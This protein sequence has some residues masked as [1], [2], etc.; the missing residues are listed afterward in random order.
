[1]GNFENEMQQPKQT[2]TPTRSNRKQNKNL[3]KFGAVA[4]ALCLCLLVYN[5]SGCRK[6]TVE[7]IY[8]FENASNYQ[9]GEYKGKI[10]TVSYDGIKLL[11]LDGSQS[12][13]LEFHMSS[14]HL[15]VSGN[16]ILLYDKGNKNLVVYDGTKKLYSYECDQAIKTAKVNKNGYVVLISDEIAYNSRVTVLDNKGEDTYIWKIGDEYIVDTDIS[17]DNKKLVAT[18]ISTTTGEIVENV[19]FVDIKAAEETGRAKS[20][21]DMPLQVNFANSG[22]A[23]VLSDTRL[24]S[25]DAS[26]KKKWE[27]SF[28]SNLLDS[29]AMDEEG[30]TVVALRGIKNNNV[31]KT[32]T[33]NG[34]KSGEYTTETQVLHVDMNQKNIAVCEKSKVSIINFSGKLVADTEIKRDV[35]DISV[36]N[37]NK[38]LMLCDDCIQLLKL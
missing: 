19:V 32:Y 33:K 29:F 8:S 26:A 4:L 22:N 38:V 7:N 2:N 35:Q 9:I 5:I 13:S 21:G 15:D 36:V 18:T 31:I 37:D 34:T 17:A 1:M 6:T 14:P 12:T 23:I 30:N 10:L 24:C 25:Y 16:M 3:I 27:A 28:E 20:S 11:N